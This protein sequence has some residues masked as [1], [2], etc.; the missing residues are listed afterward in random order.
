M[1]SITPILNVNNKHVYKQV[2]NTMYLWHAATHSH[3]FIIHAM[4]LRVSLEFIVSFFHG[5]FLSISTL[6]MLCL[7][8]TSFMSRV[9]I[10][11]F[12]VVEFVNVTMNMTMNPTNRDKASENRKKKKVLAPT[13]NWT[14]DLLI[15]RRVF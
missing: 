6:L 4:S 13:K 1:S 2:I 15:W 3:L 12:I 11:E 10:V 8:K 14:W 7:C 9:S 5:F